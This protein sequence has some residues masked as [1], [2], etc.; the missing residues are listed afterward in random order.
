MTPNPVGWFEI[1]VQDMDRAKSFYESVFQ[2][3]LD[4][5]SPPPP[6][7]GESWEGEIEMWTFPM[8]E[9][10]YGAPGALIRMEGAPSGIGGTMVYFSCEDCADEAARSAEHG[11]SILHEKAPIGEYG[12]IA[13]VSDTEGNKIGLHSH[14]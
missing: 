5:L 14:Q 7:A 1:Y 13:M 6:A 9:Q 10:E 11:G 12:F 2:V 3:T 4:P 8:S